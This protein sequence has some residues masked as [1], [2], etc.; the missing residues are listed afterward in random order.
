MQ[1]LQPFIITS[2]RKKLRYK[3]PQTEVDDAPV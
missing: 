3:Y 1:G 2:I